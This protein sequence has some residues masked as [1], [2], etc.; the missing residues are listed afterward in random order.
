VIQQSWGTA[1]VRALRKISWCCDYDM[2][3]R[4]AK[5][6]GD[7]IARYEIGAPDA[8]VETFGDNVDKPPFGHQINLNLR[9]PTLSTFILVGCDAK[10]R[11]RARLSS[12]QF[13]D[14]VTG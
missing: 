12:K 11:A 2:T 10:S 1:Q 3:S 8:E 5:F 7:H 9:I 6:Y 4:L 13:G 14:L